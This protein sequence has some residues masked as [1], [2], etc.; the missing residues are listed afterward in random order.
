MRR[1]LWWNMLLCCYVNMYSLRLILVYLIGV[2]KVTVLPLPQVS[3]RQRSLQSPPPLRVPYM[4]CTST[5][6]LFITEMARHKKGCQSRPFCAV[7]L[8]INSHLR[9]VFFLVILD[10]SN[11]DLEPQDHGSGAL[12]D[13]F[14]HRKQKW[15]WN[16]PSA[17]TA[18][19]SMAPSV[20]CVVA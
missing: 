20:V 8:A 3:V 17:S 18:I 9:D 7:L 4:Y 14:S 15:R 16:I 10:V 5:G 12:N 19:I 11:G 13:G 2:S 1:N 6:T